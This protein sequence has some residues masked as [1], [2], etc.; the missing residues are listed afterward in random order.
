MGQEVKFKCHHCSQQLEA[1]VEMAGLKLECPSCKQEIEV[2]L[3]ADIPRDPAPAVI[4]TADTSPHTATPSA[5]NPLQRVLEPDESGISDALKDALTELKAFDCSL[6]RP[7]LTIFSRQ[8][9]R[10]R[11]AKLLLGFGLFP[12]L[13]LHVSSVFDWGLEGISWSLGAYFCLL[14]MLCFN[15]IFRPDKT[16]KRTGL[17]WACFTLVVGV[18]ILFVWQQLPII[19]SLYSGTSSESFLLRMLGFIF[20]V[21]IL[22]ELCKA[23]PLIVFGRSKPALLTPRNAIYLGIMSGLGFALAEAVEYTISYWQT[24][25]T[26]SAKWVMQCVGESR[27]WL[28]GIDE[29]RL[30]D[31]LESSLPNTL[32]VYSM[33]VVAQVVRFISNPLLHAAWAGVV[34]YFV[35]ISVQR[36]RGKW[37]FIAVGIAIMAVFHGLYDVFGGILGVTIAGVSVLALLSYLAHI[38][39][40]GPKET[41]RS[42]QEQ[43]KPEQSQVG[44]I[45]GG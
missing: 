10:S 44:A 35:G 1:A 27:T 8:V 17:K 11:I 41:P 24:G 4:P 22:E 7:L 40:G 28:G 43:Q 30:V 14:W 21:G 39:S 42:P 31:S 19:S 34:G 3:G 6:C 18:P 15:S 13:I 37:V 16:V 32:R 33:F 23:L 20:G 36:D 9:L 45:Q 25:A 12:L 38:E 2:P 5:A 29:T 26:Y